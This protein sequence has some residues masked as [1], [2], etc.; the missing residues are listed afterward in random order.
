MRKAFT[1]F[2]A[3][4]GF[5]P[6]LFPLSVPCQSFTNLDFEAANVPILAPGESGGLVPITDAIPGWTVTFGGQQQSAV[7]YNTPAFGSSTAWLIGPNF[8]IPFVGTIPPIQG[9]FTAFVTSGGS[10][11]IFPASISQTGLVPAGSS[12]IQARFLGDPP[13]VSLNG[14]E[15][16]MYP[17]ATFPSYTVYG[18]DVSAFAGQVANLTFTAF[19]TPSDPFR[20]FAV[21]AIAFSPM[22]VPEPSVIALAAIGAL[23]LGLRRWRTAQR[24]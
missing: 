1:S 7:L 9:Q 2:A 18:G 23:L 21:D 10:T 17:L 16:T 13:F 3:A 24:R 12:S 11:E 8:Q 4:L 5:L 20:G 22:P 6:G 14:T 19:P 15:I